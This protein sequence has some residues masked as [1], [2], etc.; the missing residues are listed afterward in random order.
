MCARDR[1]CRRPIGGVSIRIISRPPPPHP[2]HFEPVRIAPWFAYE[3]CSLL[4]DGAAHACF[5]VWLPNTTA[6]RDLRV[7]SCA[8][9]GAAALEGVDPGI[10]KSQIQFFDDPGFLDLLDLVTQVWLHVTYT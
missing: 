8:A 6:A 5:G 3:G 10:I 9:P 1:S 4:V 2:P 7:A